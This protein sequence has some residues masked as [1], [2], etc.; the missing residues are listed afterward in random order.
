MAQGMNSGL[1]LVGCQL[2]Q[3]S[4]A[5]LLVSPHYSYTKMGYAGNSTPSYIVPSC[6]AVKEQAMGMENNQLSPSYF[7]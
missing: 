7:P 6:I 4:Y 2:L 5:A 3:G 1:A